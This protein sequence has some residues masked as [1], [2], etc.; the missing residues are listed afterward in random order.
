MNTTDFT[1]VAAAVGR[2]DLDSDSAVDLVRELCATFNFTHPNFNP[3]R[4]VR[5]CRLTEEE[6]EEV[7]KR[8]GV[9]TQAHA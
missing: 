6:Q 3:I 5:D 1:L 9:Q 2:S 7:L 4:F 8:L